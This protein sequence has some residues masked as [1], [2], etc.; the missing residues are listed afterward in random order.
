MAN[1]TPS[2]AR[3]QVIPPKDYPKRILLV[4]AGLTPQVVT[5]TLYALTRAPHLFN[6]TQLW[7]ATTKAGLEEIEK[8]LL[9]TGD[10]QIG[11]LTSDYKLP[12]FSFSD[13]HVLCLRDNAGDPLDDVHSEEAF[14]AMGDLMLR[15]LAEWTAD[16]ETAVHLSIAGGRKTMSYLAGKAM[17]LLGRPQDI[18]SHVLVNHPYDHAPLFFYPAPKFVSVKAKYTIN[19]KEKT[20]TVDLKKGK[21]TLAPVPFLRLREILPPADVEDVQK[22]S[23]RG[24]IAR[25]QKSLEGPVAS[26]DP[27]FQGV[28]CGDILVPMQDRGLALFLLLAQRREE[29]IVPSALED[30]VIEAYLDC[31]SYVLER[32]DA[33]P[34][35]SG[36]RSECDEAERDKRRRIANSRAEHLQEIADKKISDKREDWF[37]KDKTGQYVPIQNAR[38]AAKEVHLDRRNT[39]L[40]EITTGFKKALVKRLGATMASQYAIVNTGP[41]GSARYTLPEGLEVILPEAVRS[42]EN[43]Q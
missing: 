41:Y 15:K 36:A 6:P 18:L 24:L 10:D 8:H 34:M 2:P 25:A 22:L 4:I 9:P 26:F 12:A 35:S 31:Y 19:G 11:K 21:V 39:D 5:E 20:E 1:P 42:E 7:I 32:Q 33:P 37:A 16:S 40:R 17:S 28:I 23:F 43:T 30:S 14:L 29:G 13:Q 27:Q 38:G 3:A